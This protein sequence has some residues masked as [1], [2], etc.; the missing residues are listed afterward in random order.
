MMNNDE[1]QFFTVTHTAVE[2]MQSIGTGKQ[3]ERVS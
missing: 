3:Q 1:F 2:S